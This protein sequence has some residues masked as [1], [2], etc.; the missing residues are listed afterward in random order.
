MAYQATI[1]GTAESTHYLVGI[2]DIDDNFVALPVLG[3][4]IVCHS[5]YEAKQLLRKNKVKVAQLTLHTAYDEM[6]GLPT[7]APIKQVL[8]L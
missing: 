5:L 4:V 2:T 7:S 8:H 6:C 1:L 3:D